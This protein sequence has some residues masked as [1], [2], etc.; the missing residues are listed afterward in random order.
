MNLRSAA[1]TPTLASTRVRSWPARAVVALAVAAGVWAVAAPTAGG[2]STALG[3]P[4]TLSLV[5]YGGEAV[6]YAV[7][8]LLIVERR[9]GNRIGPIL[10]AFA[11]LLAFYLAADAYIRLPGTLPGAPLL[12]WLVTLLDGPMFLLVGTFFL[13]FPDGRLP[14]RRWRLLPGVQVLLVAVVTLSVALRPGPLPFYP[15]IDSPFGSSAYPGDAVWTTAYGLLV[16]TVLLSVVSLAGRWRRGGLVERAQLKWVV[17]GAVVVGLAMTL[18]GVFA[19][20]GRYSDLG[21]A[22]VGVAFGCLG[23]AIGIAVLRYRLYEI[24]R[25]IS[26]TIGWIVVTAIL[27]AVFAAVVVG[28]QLALEPATGNNTLA[29]AASTLVAAALF[30]PLRGRVQRAVD[31]RF[32]R[33][34]VDAQ[35]AIDAFGAHLRDEVDLAALRRALMETADEAVRPVAATLW[36]RGGEGVR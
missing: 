24:D 18:Y 17:G 8:G 6:L 16:A 10:L 26:R 7:I 31:R 21:D 5:L 25:I 20:P 30:Q 11:S 36:L 9:P 22:A 2:A 13:R 3:K 4:A 35:R 29:V 15:T 23:L 28:L 1:T 33:A 12:A 19:G 27:A 32:N 34:R 14:S